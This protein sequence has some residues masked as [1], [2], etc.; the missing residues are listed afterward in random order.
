MWGD[1]LQWK[2]EIERQSVATNVK[3]QPLKADDLDC[4]L[5][6]GVVQANNTPE[7]STKRF[8]QVGYGLHD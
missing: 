3:L 1:Y 7:V 5:N 2:S 4:S 6:S 8:V